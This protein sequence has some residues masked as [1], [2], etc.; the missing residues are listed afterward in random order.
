MVTLYVNSRR[1]NSGKSTLIIGMALRMMKDGYKLGFMKPIGR[2]PIQVDDITTDQDALFIKEVLNLDESLEQICPVVQSYDL[3]RDI[4]NDKK[5]DVSDKVQRVYDELAADKDIIILEGSKNIFEGSFIGMTGLELT[6][7]LNSKVLVID[8]Y[9]SDSRIVDFFL[10]IK[11]AVGDNLVGAVINRVPQ[12][13]AEYV[14]AKILTFLKKREID[15]VGVIPEDKLLSSVS[16]KMLVDIFN[17]RVLCCE[18]RLDELVENF[19]IGAMGMDSALQYFRKISNKAVIT[20]GDRSDIQIAALET[21]IKCLILTGGLIPNQIVISK[22]HE[23]G[24]P[25]ISVRND[26]FSVV[27]IFEHKVKKLEIREEQKI[28]RITSLIDNIFDFDK[29]YTSIGLK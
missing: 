8:N 29:F 13:Q 19:V 18:D 11:N 9:T 7:M 21:S 26:T 3:I 28:Q 24:I 12:D 20:G 10:S 16:I 25:I 2:M 22:A 5:I 14:K 15:I 4:Y 1:E 6:Q 27:E 23:K 17:G